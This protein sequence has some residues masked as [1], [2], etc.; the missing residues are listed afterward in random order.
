VIDLNPDLVR[1]IIDKAREYQMK[2]ALDG[3]E[4]DDAAE[5]AIE[6]WTD[7]APTVNTDDNTYM[8]FAS[9][10]DDLEPDQQACLVAMTW[11]GRGDFDIE[12]WDTAL[13]EAAQAHNARTAQYLISTPLLADYLEEALRLHGY[14]AE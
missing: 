13:D 12:E 8:E 4:A 5:A 6:D 3:A 10:V 2:D 7:D 14:E 11:L 1:F 9:A